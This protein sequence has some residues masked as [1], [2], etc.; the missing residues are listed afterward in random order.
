MK[1]NLVIITLIAFNLYTQAQSKVFKEI[2]GSV[3]TDFNEI[4]ESG[5]VIGYLSLIQIEKT[6]ADSFNYEIKLLDE[7]LNDIGET[8]FKEIDLDLQSVAYEN[9]ILCLSF[10][11]YKKEKV[12]RKERFNSSYAQYFINLEGEFVNKHE[13]AVTKGSSEQARNINVPTKGFIVFLKDKDGNKLVG[14][15]NEGKLKWEHGIG[16][17][18]PGTLQA[19]SSI[20]GFHNSGDNNFMF[21]DVDD[22][23]KKAKVSPKTPEEMNY[24]LLSLQNINNRLVYAGTLRP[25]ANYKQM[26]NLRKGMDKGLF[27]LEVEGLD[28]SKIRERVTYWGDGNSDLL[29]T[30]TTYRSDKKNQAIFANAV[31]DKDGNVYFFSTNLERRVRVGFIAAN[32]IL[33]PTVIFPVIFSSAGYNKYYYK[34]GSVLMMDPKN[35]IRI[36]DEV[37]TERSGKLFA[38]DYFGE[39]R[40]YVMSASNSETS[41]SHFVIRESN[42]YKIYNIKNKKIKSFPASKKGIETSVFPGKDGHILVLE[43]NSALKETKLS[44]VA[45]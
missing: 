20:F 37:E 12:K 43:R 28:K 41:E 17:I 38:Q 33:L 9:N 14:Y 23:K 8:K 36:Y 10:I 11:K 26:R 25:A 19:T 32:T 27:A 22:P 1:K 34:N 24:T 7:N 29:R 40:P 3:K 45:L 5:S 30:N 2:A 21:Y 31:T 13:I 39:A 15:D 6:D 44:I 42:E 35:K 4:K 18:E 16:S